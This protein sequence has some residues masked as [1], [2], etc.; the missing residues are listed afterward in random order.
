MINMK[1]KFSKEGSK[2]LDKF[3]RSKIAEKSR[4]F[5]QKLIKSGR[6][7]VNGNIVR[8]GYILKKRDVVNVDIP[9]KEKGLKKEER[10]VDIIFEDP[11]ILVIEKPRGIAVHPKE[12]GNSG[13]LINSLLE[14]LNLKIKNG[15]PGVVHR[16]DKDTTGL[17]IIARNSEATEA[18]KNQFKKRKI[19]KRYLVLVHGHIEPKH[20]EI[21]IPIGRDVKI[22]TRRKV[23]REGKEAVTKYEVLEYIKHGNMEFT[24]I[25]AVLV[26]GRTH[27]IRVHFQAIGHPVAGDRDYSN[28]KFVLMD[29]KL[30][31]ERQFLHAYKL[32]FYHPK[33]GEWMGFKS[34]LPEDLSVV[35]NKLR[36]S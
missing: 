21:N 34:E 11:D 5:I 27:Q 23:L 25:E 32:G 36:S 26:T 12:G 20:G 19:E 22:R 18:L 29:E 30:G 35:L 24:L 15:R 9:E 33:T 8:S 28:K 1:I 14:K 31:L 10:K 13:A 17:L 2:R 6:V 16:L 4:S 3:L 7:L